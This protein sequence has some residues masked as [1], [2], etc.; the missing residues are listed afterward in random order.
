MDGQPK[1]KLVGENIQIL[2]LNGHIT[3]AHDKP[4]NV[5]RE[6]VIESWSYCIMNVGPE[7]DTSELIKPGKKALQEVFHKSEA[8]N[9]F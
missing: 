7:H 5:G 6:K 3:Q 2:F 8:K 1:V 9:G 4:T